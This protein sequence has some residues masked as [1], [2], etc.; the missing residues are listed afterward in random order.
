M[1]DVQFG[2]L[3]R[4]M[5]HRRGWRQQDLADRASV[6]RTVIVDLEAGRLA[7]MRLG[8]QRQIAGALGFNL[9]VAPRG[10][11]AEADRVV[12][13][14]HALLLGASAAWL[15]DLAWRTIAEVSYSEWGE[16][17]SI[18]LLAWHAATSTLLVVEIKSEL[19]SVE[20]TLRKLD[21]KVRLAP[22]VAAAR[23]GWH[24]IHVGRLLVLPDERSER[25]RVAAHRAILDSS[26]PQ[27]SHAARRWC[28]SP[29]GSVAA[30]L[31]MSA[32]ADRGWSPPG[33]HRIRPRL[34][35]NVARRRTTADERP[36]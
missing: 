16:R 34:R 6:G 2:R 21:E 26:F 25:R 15:T 30:L 12:D 17:G 24:P 31:F 5:R 14:G 23:F 3:V 13:Q 7:G 9:E 18:D 29:V 8:T 4:A 28:R 11:G 35:T 22:A 32:G 33:R 1:H 27:R 19:V 10:L 20:A 36:R